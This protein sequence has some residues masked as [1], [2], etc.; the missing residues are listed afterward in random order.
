MTTEIHAAENAHHDRKFFHVTQSSSYQLDIMK[1]NP[2]N[3]Q[4]IIHV[5]HMC[6]K[7]S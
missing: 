6:R 7:S 4:N 3:Q 2:F 1:T 5:R